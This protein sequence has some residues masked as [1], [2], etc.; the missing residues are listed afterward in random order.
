MSSLR[1]YP[2]ALLNPCADPTFKALFTQETPESHKALE[3]FLSA[4]L[5]KKVTNTVHQPNELLDGSPS[6]KQARFD[7]TCVVDGTEAVN[8]EMQGI[9]SEKA[10]DLRAEYLVSHLLNHYVNRGTEWK[11]VP[12]VYQISV[13]NF[14]YDKTDGNGFSHY[15]MTKRNGGRLKDRLN[16]I[17]LELPKFNDGNLKNPQKLT[18]V[19]KWSKF[20]LYSKDPEKREELTNM[21]LT[22]EGI[23][24][25]ESVLTDISRN[26]SA[27]IAETQYWTAISDE[28]T[29]IANAEERGMK[30]GIE[31]GSKTKA[32]ETAKK[33]LEINVLSVEAIADVV[34]LSADEVRELK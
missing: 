31:Q 14:T 30:K 16:I 18:S 26:D 23:M 20:F 32:I 28:K 34:G 2:D 29:I 21:A 12:K 15:R 5:G 8:V 3:G 25:A 33:L 11:E 27:W 9:N 4:I 19:E 1:P 6:E 17:F 7:F 13:L 22:D 10:Y 24:N